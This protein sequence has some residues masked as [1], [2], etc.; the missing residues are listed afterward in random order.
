LALPGYKALAA[1][2]PAPL[3]GADPI[4][5]APFNPQNLIANPKDAINVFDFEPVARQA[6]P[7]AH[8]GFLAAGIDGET[9]IRANREAF[10]K[11]YLRPRRLIDV[12]HPDTSVEL[13]GVK[14]ETPIALA[15]VSAARGF[16]EESD[17]GVARAAKAKKHLQIL[18]T[19]ASESV[20]DV[21]KA[22]E[23]PVWF[24][25]YPTSDFE[26]TKALI[27]RAEAA[28][29][30]VLVVT[31][32]HIAGRNQETFL[33]LQLTDHRDCVSCHPPGVQGR[34]N[35]RHNLDGIDI[36][37][38]KTLQAPGLTWD[39]IRRIKGM[40]R[41]K[42][43]IKGVLTKEDARLCALYGMDGIVVSNHGG[44]VGD[45]GR[46]TLDCLPEVAEAVG[47]RIPVLVDG[48]FRRGT[49]ILKAL[50][51]GARAVCIGR[52]Y[53][54]GLGAFGQ[55]GVERVLEL[56]RIEFEAAMQQCGL[57]SL[58]DITPALIG[59]V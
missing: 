57:R 21:T 17:F 26:V 45:F 31:V 7:P 56:L 40:T 35:R 2:T 43:V 10:S 20:E 51:L 4:I 14:W 41:L 32:D 29:S 37:R 50:A 33:R 53:M 49:D 52:P 6:I 1:E 11:Y 9:T 47:D 8:F 24:Q 3:A 55:A 13:F 30:P 5:W 42:V 16:H 38:L 12:S 25:L 28:G 58:A 27:R 18:S 23:G 54:W 39:T 15:P 22:R 36:S 59:K 19:V 46:G 44:R 34:L 48:G